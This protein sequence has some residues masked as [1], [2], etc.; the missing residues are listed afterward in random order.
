MCKVAMESELSTEKRKLL[1]QWQRGKLLDKSALE[2]QSIPRR[3]GGNPSPLSFAQEQVW[4]FWRMQPNS[5]LYNIPIPMRLTGTL[6][7]A[8]FGEA[9]NAFAD[10]HEMLRVRFADTDEGP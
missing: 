3:A 7:A 8:A 2:R 4:F 5:P 9:L 6:Q 10:R 1:A